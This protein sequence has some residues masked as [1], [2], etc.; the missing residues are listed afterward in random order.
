MK[1]VIKGVVLVPFALAFLVFAVSNRAD[2]QVVLD[3]FGLTE[4][5]AKVSMP[6]FL[7]M[8]VAA[9]LGV[10]VGGIG[11]WWS[12]RKNREQARQFEREAIALRYELMQLR[13]KSDA[14][15]SDASNADRR[16]SHQSPDHFSADPVL[17]VSMIK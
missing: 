6:L 9:M 10:V 12:Q 14:A 13:R 5:W 3:P 2:V 15:L 17:P 7:V 4:T 8:S 16:L 1:S 11:T